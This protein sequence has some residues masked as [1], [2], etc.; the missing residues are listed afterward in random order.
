MND[1]KIAAL[2]YT[3][4]PGSRWAQLRVGMTWAEALVLG[5]L[6]GELNHRVRKG[7]IVLEP[8]P[9]RRAGVVAADEPGS[10]VKYVR[11][12]ARERPC[13]RCRKPFKSEGPGNRMCGDCRALNVSPYAL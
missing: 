7:D 2:H 4:R 10:G 12:S 11:P 6:M 13:L 5:F 9:G 3:A 8:L 1:R